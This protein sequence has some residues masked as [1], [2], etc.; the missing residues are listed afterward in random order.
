M[1]N[2]TTRDKSER[3]LTAG[4]M[5]NDIKF[6]LFLLVAFPLNATGKIDFV[7]NKKDVMQ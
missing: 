7:R 1:G 3:N 5:S 6:I 4:N 2:G